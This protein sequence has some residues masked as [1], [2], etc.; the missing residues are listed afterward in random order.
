[1][2]KFWSFTAGALSGALV[3]GVLTVLFTPASGEE[4]IDGAEARWNAAV[5]DANRAR[6]QKLRELEYEFERAKRS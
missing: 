5:E 1:M 4:L 6:E 2:S 3:G